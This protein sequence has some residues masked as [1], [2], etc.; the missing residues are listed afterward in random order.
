MKHLHQEK[1]ED[2]NGY[3]VLA[4]DVDVLA[5]YTNIAD[6]FYHWVCGACGAEHSDRW[7]DISGR[8]IKC[9]ACTKL[10]LLVRTNCKEITEWARQ[11]WVSEERDLELKRL[12]GI[13]KFNADAIL[14]IKQE[15]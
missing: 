10:N 13:E 4:A 6:G 8:V 14:K 1:Y 11:K 9:P 12:K 15:I 5:P 7:W 3:E 2:E